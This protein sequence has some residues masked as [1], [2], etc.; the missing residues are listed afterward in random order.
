M[1]SPPVGVVAELLRESVADGKRPHLTIIS[2]S[3]TPQLRIGDQVILESADTLHPDDVLVL[4][5]AEALYTHR[6]ITTLDG[7]LVTRGDRTLSYDPPWP[8][9][10]V[11]GRVC[12]RR[13]GEQTRLWSRGK[14]RWLNRHLGRVARLE[15]A[16]F[17]NKPLALDRLARAEHRLIGTHWRKGWRRPIF[18]L[19][20]TKLQL[21]R[22]TLLVLTG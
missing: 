12:G 4:E 1:D 21:W 20:R 11:V 7:Q 10:A 22:R 18:L 16:L 2:A 3:M 19:T 5:S 8:R 6:L 15:A 9:E 17:D 14:R 13:R